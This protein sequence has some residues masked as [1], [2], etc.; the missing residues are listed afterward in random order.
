MMNQTIV[1]IGDTG[2][3][4]TVL[5][6][7]YLMVVELSMATGTHGGKTHAKSIKIW[8]YIPYVFHLISYM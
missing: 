5:K 2:L 4:L 8:Y 7:C 1:K 6:I 3:S